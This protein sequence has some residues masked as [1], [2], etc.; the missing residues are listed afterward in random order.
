MASSSAPCMSPTSGPTTRLLAYPRALVLGTAIALLAWAPAYAAQAPPPT[1]TAAAATPSVLRATLDNGLRVIVVRDPLAPVVTTEI[2]Y[3][4][5]SDEAP[6]GFPGMA[7]AQEHMMFRGSPE[8]SEDQLADI[9]AAMGGDFDAD[10]QEAVTQYYFTVPAADLDVALHIEAIRMKGVLDSQVLWEKERGAIEQEVG[11]DLSSPEYVLYT[12]LLEA[13][14]KGTPYAH[15]ALGTKPSFDKT[16]GAMLQSFH[17]TWYTPN[18][19]VLVVAGDVDPAGVLAR[20]KALFAAI[21][22]KKLPERPKIALEPVESRTLSLTTDLPYGLVL[23]AFRMP[24]YANPDFAAAQVLE[25]VLDSQRG[26]LYALVPA[27]KALGAGF[28]MGTMREAGLGYGIAAFPR[29]ADAEALL[30]ELRSI[31]ADDVK[32]G[33]PADLVDAAKRRELADLEFQRNS[34]SGL[35]DAWAQAVAVQGLASPEEG[36]QA[37]EKVTVEDVD[38]VARAFL[39]QKHGV[40]AVLTPQPSGAPVTAKGFGG[41]ESFAPSNPKPVALPD[42]AAAAIGRLSVPAT[43][44]RPTVTKLPNGLTVIVQPQSISS[45]VS[46]VGA[47]RNQPDLETPP[48]QEGVGRVLDRLFSW[49]S[50]SLD[51]LAFQKALD[52]IAADESAGTGFSLDVLASRFE[53]GVE[54]LADNELHP[55]LPPEAFKVVQAQTARSLAGELES[56]GYLAARAV[57]E[58]LFPKNDPT[59]RQATPKSVTALTLEDVKAY[60]TRVFRPDLTTIVVIGDVT[61][62][63]ATAVVATYFGGWSAK[64]PKPDTILPQVPLNEASSTAVPDTSRVQDEV[65]L[66]ET[67][68]L[69]RANPDRYTLE[70]GNHVLGGAFYATRLYRDLRQ[71]EG[72][73]YTVSSSFDIGRTRAVYT[74]SYACDPDK[75][76][77]AR[78]IVVRDLKAMAAEPVTEAELRQAKGLLLR[79]MQLSE[80]S[81]DSIAGGLLARSLHELPLDEPT[82]AAQHYLATTV[83]E[84]QKAFA[85]WVRP[86]AFVQV[87]QGPKPS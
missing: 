60:Y 81:L 47:I 34:I 73:V 55:A 51:R 44:V 36:V 40:F 64:G 38:R 22:A 65:T 29:G 5:G 71:K 6:E 84:V 30:G 70:V 61:P 41:K 66:A 8:L 82:R 31:L 9:T 17:E 76:A 32:N 69:T 42:W 33:F 52:D 58:G 1:P 13:M 15:D 18:N 28:S 16:T 46:V 80:A 12:R 48:G 50:T 57:S 19:A 49:G 39:D 78:A 37:I 85:R 59:L 67:L 53:R 63:R 24:G 10:T 4:V 11:R 56:P 25:D 77:K 43:T 3:L 83:E 23:A 7:H 21:P 72:L 75:V 26:S 54:L 86:D 79:E 45:T 74:V 27:G 62:E 35:A 68:G 87:T 2:N 20:V 14:F